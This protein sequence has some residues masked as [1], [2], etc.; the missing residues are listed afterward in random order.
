[1]LVKQHILIHS[2]YAIGGGGSLIQEIE[3]IDGNRKYMSN[4][5]RRLDVLQKQNQ[6][7]QPN[8]LEFLKKLTW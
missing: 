1:M 3:H 5:S 2:S 6:T 4:L 7:N 8:W